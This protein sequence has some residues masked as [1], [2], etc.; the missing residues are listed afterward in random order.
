MNNAQQIEYW[1]GPVGERWA[2][3]Q[4]TLDRSLGNISE[5][6]ISFVGAKPGE[7]L[8]DIGCGCGTTTLTF[9]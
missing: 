2:R 3:L 1:N 6:F 5:S 7:R 4:D 8:L 9:A